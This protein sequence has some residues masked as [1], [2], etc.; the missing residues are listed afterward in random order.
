MAFLTSQ[1]CSKEHIFNLTATH[2]LIVTGSKVD[3][4]PIILY[5]ENGKFVAT[6]VKSYQRA[7]ERE[8]DKCWDIGYKL[9]RQQIM[10]DLACDIQ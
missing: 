2:G 7:I 3:V 8:E 4:E 6:F 1:T 10:A 9:R 5:H